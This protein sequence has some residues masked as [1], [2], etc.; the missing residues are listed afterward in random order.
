[1][2]AAVLEMEDQMS[3]YTVI[4]PLGVYSGGGEP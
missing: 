1:M 3:G 4:F 2:Y